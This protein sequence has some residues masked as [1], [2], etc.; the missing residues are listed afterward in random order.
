MV[1]AALMLE[2]RPRQG[3]W[4]W[5]HYGRTGVVMYAVKA[6]DNHHPL[7]WQDRWRLPSAGTAH[8]VRG[9]AMPELSPLHCRRA[10][11]RW[12]IAGRTP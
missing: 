5:K 9:V 10:A 4:H 1:M 2:P 11:L 12:L 8:L 6:V 7:C 3:A